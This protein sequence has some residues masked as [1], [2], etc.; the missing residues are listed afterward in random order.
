MSLRAWTSEGAPVAVLTAP[1][2]LTTRRR[3]V[4]STS[5]ESRSRGTDVRLFGPFRLDVGEQRLWRGNDE[6]KLR[7][8]A[9]AIL[10]FLTANPLRLATQEE[11]VEAVW[12]KIAMSEGLLRTH[13]S[14]VRRVLGEGAIETVVGRGYRF[15]LEVDAEKVPTSTPRKVEP[16]ATHGGLVGRG[17]EMDFLRQVFETVVDQQRRVIFV[18]GEPGIGKTRLIDDFLAQIAAPHGALIATGSCVEQFG[19]GE[20]YLPVF[21]ALGAACRGPDGERIVDVLG[22]HAPTWLA[23]M[24]GLV[25]DENL[26]ALHLRIQGATQGRM[27]RE[28]AEAFDV[29]AVERPLVLV[30][31]DMQWSDR[32]TTD[33]VAMLGARREPS[34]VLVIVTCRQAEL[35]KGDGLAKI[36]A[37]LRSRKQALTLILQTLTE[38]DVAEYLAQRF[39][40]ARFPK[41]LASTIHGMTGGNPLFT[42]AVVDDLESLGMIRGVDGPWQLTATVAEV[43]SRRPDTV[44]QLIDIQIDRLSSNEQR[45]LETASLAGAQFA[46]GSVAH[47]LELPVDEVD[48]ICEGLARKQR[49]LRFVGSE[50]WPN[51]TIQSLYGFVHALF[52]DA[53][54]ARIPSATRRV[55]HRRVAEALEAAYG[56]S[57]ET[58]ASELAIH[59]GEARVI[60]KAVRYHCVAGERAMRRFGRADALTQF[61]RARDLLTKLPPSGDSD[62]AELAVLKHVGPAI[63]ALQGIQ[64][65][66]LEQ[67]FARTAE[68]SRKLGD[69]RALLSALLGRQRCYFVHG[70]LP[71]VE[72]YEVEVAEVL[73]RLGDPVAAAEA[74]VVT[75]SARLFR[76]Q[77][78]ATLRPLTEACT[79]LDAAESDAA[80]I[81]NAPVVGLWSG[82]LVVLSWLR[83]APDEAMT[84]ADKMLARAGALRDPFHLVTALTITA[85][86]Q[87]WRREPEKTLETARRALEVAREAGSPV[88][89]GRAISLHHWAAT[90][91]EPRAAKAHF[92]ELSSTLSGLLGAGP[93]GRTAFTPCVAQVYAA[94][95]HADRA[96]REVDDALAFVESSDERA[97]SSE[98]HRLRGELLANV[99]P[100]EAQRALARALEISR[101]QGARSFELRAE[102]TLAKL[103]CGATKPARLET[104]RR[105]YAS[106]TDGFATGDLVEAKALL[107]AS[108]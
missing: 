14:E 69:D 64:D 104:L 20:A 57:S 24:P 91:L 76:G 82:H 1:A 70:E 36:I 33:L 74:T 88:W 84:L 101:Q 62:Q 60:G 51:G 12:G 71:K 29:L 16:P 105:V 83:G 22:R 31:E 73:A 59:F 21:A 108:K 86:A 3:M 17:E 99:D 34:R 97:W 5:P 38:T 15:L 89:L 107:D 28:L 47:A 65:P 32:S 98:L 11:L 45:I 2:D 78:A 85:A 40:D 55:W 49:F 35:T 23:Q 9:F 95:G 6:L 63:I 103:D 94:A 25:A 43:A 67:T 13:M 58:V 53:A 100:A 75:W 46:A 102:L 44:R 61:K 48:A 4:S 10:R 90:V 81:V 8:K 80:R 77:L 37:E 50:P 106:F 42:I 54:L 52:R 72:H 41:E 56:E 18:T 7:R 66:L 92:E 87:M 79:V 93:Y 26:Q 27:L 96:L 30:L 68:L 39:S 19:T